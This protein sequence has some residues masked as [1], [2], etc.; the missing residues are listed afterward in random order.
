LVNLKGFIIFINVNM[1][2]TGFDRQASSLRWC[3]Q[4]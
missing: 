1:G 3:K 2:S 4:C